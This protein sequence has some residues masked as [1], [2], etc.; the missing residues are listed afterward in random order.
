MYNTEYAQ[1]EFI[2]HGEA[3]LQQRFKNKF[4]TIF[5]VGS[6]IGEW[7]RMARIYQPNAEIHQFEII[8]DTYRQMLSNITI[9]DK[10]FPNG[11]GL[12]DYNGTLSMKYKPEY[13]A[14]STSVLDLRLDNSELRT[15]LVMKGDDYVESRNIK[16][17]DFLK[18]DT[19]GA[20]EKVFKG[21]E[22]TLKAGKVKI[23]QFEYNLVCVLTK[24]LLIDSYKYLTPL[25][26]T[27]GKLKNGSIEFKEYSLPDEDFI[28]PDYIAVHDSVKHLFNL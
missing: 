3:W 5:D 21:F 9:D 20:E 24:W 14:V 2:N 26:F 8:S 12:S 22:E 27:L 16:S 1:Q 6:N 25:G 17:I 23:I 11:F 15:G 4:N 19:E 13:S 18:I 7:S 28:G 10:M